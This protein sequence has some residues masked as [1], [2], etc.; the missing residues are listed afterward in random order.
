MISLIAM[1]NMVT[2]LF[3]WFPDLELTVPASG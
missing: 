2:R 1:D 3:D